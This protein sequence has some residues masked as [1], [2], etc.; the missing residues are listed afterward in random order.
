MA[1]GASDVVH[2]AADADLDLTDLD[3][4]G[5]V[6]DRLQAGATRLLHVQAGS[7]RGELR[8]E[9]RLADQ[10]EVTAV[11]ENRTTGNLAEALALKAEASHETIKG[12]GEHLLVGG[13]GVRAVRTRERD[14]IATENGD[15]TQVRHEV[16]P[17]P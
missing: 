12:G 3:L 1:I 11:L 17:S 2:A 16:F 14:A 13:G 5:D 8:A 4:V 7:L 15:A 9:H 10:V 6:V